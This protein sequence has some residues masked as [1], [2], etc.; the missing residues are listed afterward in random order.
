MNRKHRFPPHSF[1]R[2]Q[3]LSVSKAERFWLVLGVGAPWRRRFRVDNFSALWRCIF[4]PTLQRH[5]LEVQ[6]LLTLWAAWE[7]SSTHKDCSFV[8]LVPEHG[9]FG[10]GPGRR[11]PERLPSSVPLEQEPFLPIPNMVK[12]V[13]FLDRASSKNG[14]QSD[15]SGSVLTTTKLSRGTRDAMA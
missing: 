14:G 6:L 7:G 3:R 13:L 10:T 5:G 15:S 11:L 12:S 1:L 9:H 4:G 8:V 2:F